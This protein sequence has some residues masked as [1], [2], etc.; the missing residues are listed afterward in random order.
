MLMQ[1]IV[2]FQGR[3]SNWCGSSKDFRWRSHGKNYSLD[4]LDHVSE[5]SVMGMSKGICGSMWVERGGNWV[6][7]MRSTSVFILMF[8]SLLSWMKFF[9]SCVLVLLT[10]LLRLRS[11]HLKNRERSLDLRSS[12]R[13][14]LVPYST[15]LVKYTCLYIKRLGSGQY[16]WF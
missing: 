6:D 5:G 2:S 10:F 13:K 7:I 16:Q 8:W 11:W 14:T 3:W 1:V 12:H 15:G 9:K 4:E